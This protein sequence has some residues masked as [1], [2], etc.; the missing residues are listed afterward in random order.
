MDSLASASATTYTT[1][2]ARMVW[3]C[4]KGG[5]PHIMRLAGSYLSIST[6]KGYCQVPD[7]DCES[8]IGIAIY[9]RKIS[10]VYDAAGRDLTQNDCLSPYN[11]YLCPS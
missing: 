8:C 10:E 3:F 4:F 9:I 2:N 6:E 7:M 1:A 11:K 5:F